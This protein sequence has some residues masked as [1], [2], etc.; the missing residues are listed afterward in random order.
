[1]GIFLMGE[2]A[3]YSYVVPGSESRLQGLGFRVQG[4]GFQGSGF[5]V[6]GLGFSQAFFRAC[7]RIACQ[8]DFNLPCRSLAGT[9]RF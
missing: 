8:N 4:S 7:A 2:V 6:Q 9:V 1:M 5:R 3:L